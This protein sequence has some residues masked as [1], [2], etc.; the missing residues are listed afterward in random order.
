MSEKSFEDVLKWRSYKPKNNFS[1][2][3]DVV[4]VVMRDRVE[5][6]CEK[7]NPLNEAWEKILPPLL[8]ENCRIDSL[9]AGTL[10]VVASSPSYMYEMRL[11]SQTLLEQIQKS[12][13]KARVQKIKIVIG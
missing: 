7:L 8:A 3:G 4:Q 1:S 2:L 9:S 10:R 13:P 6:R 5:P 12:C 11:C